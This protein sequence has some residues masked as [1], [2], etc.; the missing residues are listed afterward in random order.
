MWSLNSR[1]KSN[2]CPASVERTAH[3]SK[4]R[5]WLKSVM[6]PNHIEP[7]PELI[8]TTLGTSHAHNPLQRYD[9]ASAPVPVRR[10][11]RTL[12]ANLEHAGPTASDSPRRNKRG[13]AADLCD[14]LWN[15]PASGGYCVSSEARCIVTPRFATY[16]VGSMRRRRR[17]E[18]ES[19]RLPQLWYSTVT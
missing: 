3:S 14:R 6:S 17:L 5:Y 7:A 15:T 12:L 18:R 11:G 10:N 2:R 8:W 13:T 1:G 4:V 9:V 19:R 16:K